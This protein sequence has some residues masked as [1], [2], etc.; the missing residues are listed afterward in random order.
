MSVRLPGQGGCPFFFDPQVLVGAESNFS[1]SN[2][3]V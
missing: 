3:I 2:L 1:A